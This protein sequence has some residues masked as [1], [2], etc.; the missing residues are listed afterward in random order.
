MRRCVP[1]AVRRP[2]GQVAAARI[3]ELEDQVATLEKQVASQATSAKRSAKRPASRKSRDIDPGDAV[4]AGVAVEEPEPLDK[5]AERALEN[6]E[7]HLGKAPIEPETALQLERV[8]GMGADVWLNM[9]AAYRL[10]LATAESAER[11]STELAWLSRFPVRELQKLGFQRDEGH[12][13]RR[14]ESF[15]PLFGTGSVEACRE[16][17]GERAAVFLPSFPII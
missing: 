6:L 15:R 16:R 17:F 3:A 12:R 13:K 10:R 7:E 11:L 9:E 4:P 1:R 5:E 14:Q 2:G 8:L